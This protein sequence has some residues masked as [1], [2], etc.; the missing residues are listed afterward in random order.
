MLEPMLYILRIK[1]V[2]KYDEKNYEFVNMCQIH[3]K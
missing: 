3:T 2:G 1:I